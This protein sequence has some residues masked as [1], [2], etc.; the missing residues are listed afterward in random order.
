MP[1]LPEAII[2]VLRAFAPMF[3]RSVCRRTSKCSGWP[4]AHTEATETANFNAFTTGQRS[5]HVLQHRGGLWS[6]STP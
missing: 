6:T 5:A 4:K 3:S 1:A 2:T